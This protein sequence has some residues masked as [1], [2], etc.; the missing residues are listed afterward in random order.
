MTTAED[1][2]WG[3]GWPNCQFAAVT[4]VTVAGITFQV[5][6]E[7]K[8]VFAAFL[9]DFHKLV[10]PLRKEQCWSFVCRVIRGTASTPSN[11]SWGLAVD[12][13]SVLHP[14]RA[15]DTFTPTQRERIRMLLAQPGYRN[16]KWGADFSSNRDEMHFEYVGTP[17]DAFA[18]TKHI[19]E[20]HMDRLDP[21]DIELIAQRATELICRDRTHIDTGAAIRAAVDRLAANVATGTPEAVATAVVKD[22]LARLQGVAGT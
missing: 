18:D 14:W 1:R 9:A 16:I 3:P 20:T 13:N 6:T 8:V 19:V 7:T 4:G 17:D 22:L 11:H 15:K 2:G 21:R 5:R 10:E 12:L